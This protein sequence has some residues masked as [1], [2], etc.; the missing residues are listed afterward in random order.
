MVRRTFRVKKGDVTLIG[1]T[2]FNNEK[3]LPNMSGEFE[4]YECMDKILIIVLI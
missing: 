1:A 2:P 3:S 4:S